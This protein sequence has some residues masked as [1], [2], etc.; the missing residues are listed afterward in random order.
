MSNE[1]DTQAVEFLAHRDNE[2]SRLR[3]LDLSPDQKRAKLVFIDSTLDSLDGFMDGDYMYYRGGLKG[4]YSK[5]YF[6][7][8]GSLMR[9][10]GGGGEKPLGYILTEG[11]GY[12]S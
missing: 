12:D 5:M 2:Q 10:V 8:V 9:V 7:N 3:A 1:A 4:P 11:V 6:Y